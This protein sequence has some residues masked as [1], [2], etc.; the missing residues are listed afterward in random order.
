[1]KVL[2]LLTE[3][4]IWIAI[5]NTIFFILSFFHIEHSFDAQTL[6]DMLTQIGVLIVNLVSMFLA[7]WSYLKPKKQQNPEINS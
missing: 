2:R 7:L 5:I 4:R 6:G 3:R 1:M